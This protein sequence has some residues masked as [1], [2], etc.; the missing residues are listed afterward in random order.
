MFLV[1]SKQA[2][3][4][5]TSVTNRVFSA[6]LLSGE[7]VDKVKSEF[8]QALGGFERTFLDSAVVDLGANN[9]GELQ[10]IWTML[11]KEYADGNL[12]SLAAK[13]TDIGKIKHLAMQSLV[14]HY[15]MID[16]V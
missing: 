15:L 3:T 16:S 1:K 4:L 8:R 13:G 10:Q 2:S 9:A 6:V 7:N 14:P 12:L 5:K 11:E